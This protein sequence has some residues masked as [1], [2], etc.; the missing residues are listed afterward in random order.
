[1]RLVDVRRERHR[2]AP[3]RVVLS[4]APQHLDERHRRLTR[5]GQGRRDG[6]GIGLALALPLDRVAETNQRALTLAI[7]L[8]AREGQRVDDLLVRFPPN[9]AAQDD[10]V[11]LNL[12]VVQPFERAQH[13]RA[14]RVVRAIRI[15]IEEGIGAQDTLVVE[16]TNG[17]TRGDGDRTIVDH[18]PARLLEY[19]KTSAR[20]S[21][22]AN[23]Q[24][25]ARA[26]K[27]FHQTFMLRRYGGQRKGIFAMAYRARTSFVV[28]AALSLAACGGG[29]MTSGAPPTSVGQAPTGGGAVTTMTAARAQQLAT[30][31]STADADDA[32]RESGG[33][34]AQLTKQT[35]IGSTVDPTNGDQNPYGLDVAKADAGL[36]KNGDLVIC[37]FNDY[38]NVQGNGTT[39]VALHPQ[40]GSKPTHVAQDASLKGCNALA[41]APNDN[42]WAAAF[43]ANLNPIFKPDGSLVTMLTGGPWHGPF[44]ETFSPTPGP[45]GTA[46]FYVSNAGD[47]SIV[48][49]NITAN[50]FTEDVIATGFAINGGAPGSILGPSGLQFDARRDRLFVVDGADNS[51]T[52]INAVS[53]IP[54][55]GITLQNGKASGIASP[56]VRRVFA[57]PPLNGPISSA[58]LPGG[59]LVLGNT[60]DANGTNLMVEISP[61]GRLISTKNVD[62]GAAG[63]LFGMVATGT[64]NADTQLYFNDDNMNT[65]QVLTH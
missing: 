6:L 10:L 21:A 61:N 32:K 59:H 16:M 24:P 11:V 28:V 44:G 15:A 7:E 47:G 18:Q 31:A 30:Q 46:A 45:F 36:L 42:F 22:Y 55:G 5:I 62:T 26:A 41:V 48:R 43:S 53:F 65:L 33:V 49:V 54:Q 1:M 17:V 3:D 13:D 56:L 34:L 37:N 51:L 58:F 25:G 63:A 38:A 20:C 64:N 60:L 39:V 8:P 27:R 9:V 40:A 2:L 57:G 12:D 19:G 52:V 50:G 35:T 4:A 14:Q 29:G 23:A